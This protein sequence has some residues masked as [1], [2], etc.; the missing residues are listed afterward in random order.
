ML[1]SHFRLQFLFHFPYGFV[2]V[3]CA[4]YGGCFQFRLQKQKSNSCLFFGLAICWFSDDCISSF[5]FIFL[6]ILVTLSTLF[7]SIF[8]LF[9]FLFLQMHF[10]VFFLYHSNPHKSFT[11]YYSLLSIFIIKFQHCTNVTV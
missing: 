1:A 3:D 8:V 10:H 9:T 4:G 5:K 2:L 7:D 6:S 11:R